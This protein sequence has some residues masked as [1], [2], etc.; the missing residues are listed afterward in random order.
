M[1]SDRSEMVQETD[2]NQFSQKTV[3]SRKWDFGDFNEINS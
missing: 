2:F 3:F 1:W